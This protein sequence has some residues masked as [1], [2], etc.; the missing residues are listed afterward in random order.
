MLGNA[1]TRDSEALREALNE[2]GDEVLVT[3]SRETAEWVSRAADAK[4]AG[5]HLVISRPRGEVSPSEAARILGVSR[6]Q[7]R[8][9]MNQGQLAFRKVGAHYRVTLESLNAFNEWE[10]RR[11]R[12]GMD[13][14]SKL[15]NE[16][17]LLE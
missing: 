12:E 7:V 9:I 1:L 4:L 6:A 13:E 10:Q 17:G 14:L 2:P 5:G 16:L 11:M 15:Q 8:K 3:L